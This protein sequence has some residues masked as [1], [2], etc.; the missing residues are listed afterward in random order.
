MGFRVRRMSVGWDWEKKGRII[1]REG[2]KGKNK[3]IMGNYK[4]KSIKLKWKVQCKK[5][6]MYTEKR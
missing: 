5:K 1:K 2:K 3:S 6:L 4:L